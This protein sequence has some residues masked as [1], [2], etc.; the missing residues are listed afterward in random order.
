MQVTFLGG[1]AEVGRLAVLME[2]AGHRFL[3]DYGFTASK[4]PQFPERAPPLDA[5]F[6]SHCHLD[7]SG[8]VPEATRRHM[9]PVHCTDLTAEISELLWYDSIKIADLGL[10]KRGEGGEQKG[11]IGT[12]H[13]IPPEQALGKEVDTRADIYSLG[14]TF[15][16]MITGRTL[17]TGKTAKEIVLKHIKE[18]PP[19]ASSVEAGIPDELDLVLARMLAKEPAKRYQTAKELIAALEEICAQHGIKGAIIKRGVG[20]RVLIPLV[21]LL[22]GAAAAV[23]F[24]AVRGPEIRVDPKALEAQEKAERQAQLERERREAEARARRKTEAENKL[25]MRMNTYTNLRLELPFAE[26]YDDKNKAAEREARWLDLA[27]EFEDFAGSDVAQEFDEELE[28]ASKAQNYAKD[29]RDDLRQWK[30]STVDRR[31]KREAKFKEAKAIDGK[32]RSQLAGLRAKRHYEAA[33]NLCDLAA[34]GK[35]AKEDPFATITG[36]EWVNPVNP[37]I[38]AAA[39]EFPEIKEVVESSQKYFKDEAPRIV[40]EAV[41]AGTAIVD[42]AKELP[43]DAARPVV[44]ASIK[45]LQGVRAFI[46][47]EVREK[48]PAIQDL[49]AAARTQQTRLE[50]ML[51]AR[52]LARLREDR[53]VVRDTQRRYCS[54]DLEQQ[55]NSVMD[56][57]F[58]VVIDAWNRLLVDGKVETEL[59]QRFAKERID[60]LRWCEYLFARFHADVVSTAKGVEKVLATLEVDRVPFSDRELTGADLS[61]KGAE[62]Y[63]FATNKYYSGE[64]AFAYDRFPMDWIYNSLF[65]YKNEPR[66]K[67]VPAELEFALGAFC[68]ETMQYGGAARHFGRVLKIEDQAVQDTYGA[69]A[70][71]LYERAVREDEARR[72]WEAI[73]REVETATTV[74]ALAAL[75]KRVQE[76]PQ[77]Y[78]GTIFCL[79]IMERRDE[80]QKD[81]FDAAYPEIPAAP[82]PPEPIDK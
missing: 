62:R 61:S 6:V 9:A 12:P 17:F 25:L 32:L 69:A 49:V 57:E 37:E 72:E 2:V 16:R 26:V 58:P 81:F 38:R 63:K 33:W 10:A 8:L 52:A 28:V 45:E 65:L 21:L 7:H 73:C 27:K 46:D 67:E 3:F 44:D 76:F 41:T 71:M 4:P 15:F 74:E 18:P 22:V 43:D 56:C 11:I 5:L 29:I 68:F 78:E 20:K 79:D 51:K 54:L 60:M 23:Y 75:T 1:A 64:S 30:E 70:R 50:N 42:K 14:A 34:T 53:L 36:W 13:F 48:V 55:P 80:P 66:W 77:K 39:M 35:P 24:L 19:A 40:Q 31:E 82:E 47:G 59:Y